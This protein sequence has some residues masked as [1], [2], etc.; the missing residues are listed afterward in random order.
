MKIP[1]IN[2]IRTNRLQRWKEFL[3]PKLHRLSEFLVL[4]G[5]TTAGNLLYGFLCVRLLP[6]PEYA[7][8]A[9]VF[10][11]LGTLTVLMD[12]GICSTLLPL[13][14]ER[15]DDRQ[16][17]ADYVAS[18]RQLAHWLYI[19]VAP[20]I[21]VV[22]PLVVRRQQWSW[23][24]LAA[25]LAILLVAGWCAR[26][27]GAYGAVLIIRRDR[28]V[29]YRMQ[30]ISS[31]GTLFLLGVVWSLHW[32]NAFTAILI[33]VAGIVF[34][35]TAYYFRAGRLLGVK[36]HSSKEKRN[37]I[38]HLVMPSIPN[39]IF[40]AFQGQIS[41]LLITFFGKTTA[42]ASIGA[43]N[44]LSR[45]FLLFGQM[46]PLLIEP[47]FAKLPS[48]H[49]KHNY[50][51][52]VAIFGT[53][54]LC[55]VGAARAFPGIFLWVLGPQ[56]SH[57]R[58]EVFLAITAGAVSFFYDVIVVMNNARRFVYWW[59]G[60]VTI[61]LVLSVQVIFLVKVDLSSVRA[62]LY[63]GI[64]TATVVLLVNAFTGIYGIVRGPRKNLEL[65]AIGK[66]SEFP[67]FRE[68][69]TFDRRTESISTDY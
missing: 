54:C 23:K 5:I 51:S 42:V 40:Y 16:L 38:V 10:G 53:F 57:L 56:Y 1:F 44:R 65:T 3:S 61:V 47:Y 69:M 9:V 60:I 25:M 32:F 7:E 62:V 22:Y 21:V 39:A 52:V 46:N 4:Q 48:T 34:I 64:A 58:F 67:E 37:A 20:L 49:L 36:G 29:W 27:S 26:V 50:L 19:A 63:M 2:C 35:S 17:V 12:V 11:F 45:F 14:G 31:L 30:M 18:L 15:I 13:V 6:I 43:L 41:L 33:N 8:F 66:Q 55:M 28:T 59:N 68:P 24:V